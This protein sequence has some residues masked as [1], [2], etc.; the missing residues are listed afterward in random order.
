M[1]LWGEDDEGKEEE[2]KEA[3]SIGG[4]GRRLTAGFGVVCG[5]A[6]FFLEVTDGFAGPAM[7]NFSLAITRSIGGF[8]ELGR[9]KGTYIGKLECGGGDEESRAAGGL[10]GV[11]ESA[12]M[13]SS[14]LV[15]LRV[16]YCVSITCSLSSK[17]LCLL[18]TYLPSSLASIEYC[19]KI[20][21][22]IN[23]YIGRTLSH[24]SLQ[25][26]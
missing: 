6:G 26:A 13:E 17:E 16:R 22:S 8:S 19:I 14:G 3:K 21:E 7:I 20:V 15:K 10:E 18:L 5:R 24:R 1:R 25:F 9:Y 2:E 4:G 23:R 12:G 11:A